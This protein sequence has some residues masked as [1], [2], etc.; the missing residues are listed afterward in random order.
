MKTVNI[1]SFR[2]IKTKYDKIYI[3][4]APPRSASTAFVRTFWSQPSIGFY[5][6]EPFD[7]YYHKD[8]SFIEV[9]RK[10]T[11]ALN[12]GN[13]YHTRKGNSIII[14]EMTFQ[15]GKYLP[16]LIE[17]TSD[18]IIFIIRDPRLSIY[19][20]MVKRKEGDQD[21]I[22]SLDQT[23]WPDL[24]NQVEFCRRMQIPYIIIDSW[25]FRNNPHKAFK[26]IFNKLDLT[27]YAEIIKWRP[28][29][30][31]KIG[32]LW[33]EQQHWYERVLKSTG[34]LAPTEILPDLEVFPKKNG[35]R[36]HVRDCIQSYH[37]LLND[38]EAISF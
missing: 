22:F 6:H 15:V 10:L 4:I 33:D 35:F 7:L 9:K 2:E 16:S 23:G 12:L 20:R 14:K 17:L 34:I 29:R 3:V 32:E 21:P 27:Y 26:L 19:S 31:I 13:I 8:T 5:C 36:D 30:N 1:P 37:E 24:V 28:V 11:S 18:P 25:D 38:K